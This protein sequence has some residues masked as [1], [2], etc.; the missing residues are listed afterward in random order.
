MILLYG[1]GANESRPIAEE[2]RQSITQLNLLGK[3]QSPGAKGHH[4]VTASLG[5]ATLLP[6]ENWNSWMN[7]ADAHRYEAKNSGRNRV[8]GEGSATDLDCS[9]LNDPRLA[10]KCLRPLAQSLSGEPIKGK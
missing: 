4:T 7:R 5:L 8:G 1:T 6:Q 2:Y 3:G 9:A 10:Q